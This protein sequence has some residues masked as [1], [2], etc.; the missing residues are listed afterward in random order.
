MEVLQF[1]VVKHHIYCIC[2]KALGLINNYRPDKNEVIG[3]KENILSQFIPSEKL[4][5]QCTGHKTVYHTV[6]FN[7][8]NNGLNQ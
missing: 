5:K 4:T 3:E 1:L 6:T 7:T 8:F 2:L